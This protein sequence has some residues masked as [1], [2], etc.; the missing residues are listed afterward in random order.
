[1]KCTICALKAGLRPFREAVP[2]IPDERL[3][4]EEDLEG[5]KRD[6]DF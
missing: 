6:G 2:L 4:F 5:L 3:L 1:M